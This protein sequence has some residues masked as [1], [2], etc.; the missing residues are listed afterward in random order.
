[1]IRFI[2][3]SRKAFLVL[4]VIPV[5]GALSEVLSDGRFSWTRVGLLALAGV[6]TSVGVWLTPNEEES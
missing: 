1:M 5:L 3:R 2:R 4:V 6:F